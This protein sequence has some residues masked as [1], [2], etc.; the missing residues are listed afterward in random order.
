MEEACARPGGLAL[1]RRAL[2]HCALPPGA[3]LLDVG[4]GAGATV[5]LLQSLGHNAHGIDLNAPTGRPGLVRGDATALPF[6]DATMDAVLFECSLSKMAH[7]ENAL[8]EARR[9]L[10]PAGRLVVSDLFAQGREAD[11]T[12][13][14]G[15]VRPWAAIR[16]Q[17]EG[18]GFACQLFEEHPE[19]LTAYWGELVFHHGPDAAQEAMGGTAEE[20]RAARCGY[21]L[22]VFG[23]VSPLQSW[24]YA[25]AGVPQ[26]DRQALEDWRFAQIR[27]TLHTARQNSPFFREH[28]AGV[29]PE[30]VTKAEALARL[31]F[32]TAAHLAQNQQRMLCVSLGEVARVRSFPTSGSTGPPKRVWF[33]EQDMK[34]TI[35]FFSVGMRPLAAPSQTVAILLSDDKPGGIGDLLQ[36]GLARY[37]AKGVIGGNVRNAEHTHQTA[38]KADC[39]VGVPAELLY[40]CRKYPNLRPKTVLLSADYVPPAI[41]KALE[42]TWGC[43]VFVHY[44]LTET[45][46]GLA[47]QC[48]ARG[49]QHLRAADFYAEI[50]DPATGAVLP[51]G[52]EG[53][54]VLTSLRSQALPL[55]RYRTGDVTSLTHAC[56]CGCGLPG[57]GPVRGRMEN[58]RHT[59]NIHRLDDIVFALPGVAGYHARLAGE[60]LTL[61][62]EGARLD[63][64]TLTRQTGIKTTVEY[65]PAPP[66]SGQGKRRLEVE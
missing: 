16:A 29:E 38:A 22:A 33:T 47:V 56:P 30:S 9:V 35:D 4:C 7:P 17:I 24:V 65:G 54:L 11:F 1:T 10:K 58:L 40:L 62:V 48:A 42:E 3:H 5:A 34:R 52:R 27:E 2:A 18:A 46:Y 32:T 20:L 57:L 36:Q 14:L 61:T 37:G 26:G 50:I 49:K 45:C 53:E 15:R 51:V 66:F 19:A 6:A 8:A 60:R 43:T 28:L 31:P 23:P 39:L 63:K 59:V 12:G 13:V 41:I 25:T 55:V 21:F 64:D 44:G